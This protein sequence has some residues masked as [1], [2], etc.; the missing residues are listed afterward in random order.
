MGSRLQDDLDAA[1]LLVPERLVQFGAHVAVL[2]F[3]AE[4]KIGRVEL[5]LSLGH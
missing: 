5:F 2:R 3:V 4:K 1:V